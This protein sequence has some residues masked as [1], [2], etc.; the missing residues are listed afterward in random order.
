MLAPVTVMQKSLGKDEAAKLL[1]FEGTKEQVLLE[2]R[3]AVCAMTAKIESYVAKEPEAP[4]RAEVL[5]YADDVSTFIRLIRERVFQFD[6]F[7]ADMQEMLES[8]QQK[9]PALADALQESDNIV[10]EIRDMVKAELPETSLEEVRSWTDQIKLLAADD[11]RDNLA[12]VKELTQQCRN[13]AGTQDD[14]ARNLSV[15]TIR[16]M[17]EAARM[18]TASPQ[19]VRIARADD[20]PLPAD[21]AQAHVVGTVP[22]VPA[23]EQSGAQ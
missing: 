22:Q 9:Q 5:P 6:Q 8:E 12:A 19:H 14:M 16:L 7:A 23:E 18:G 11:G 20:R 13:V 3:N 1:D 2:H 4:P 17:E 21:S 15:V 10:A